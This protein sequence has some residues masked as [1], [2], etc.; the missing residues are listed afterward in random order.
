MEARKEVLMDPVHPCWVCGKNVTAWGQRW[1]MHHCEDAKCVNY[2][3]GFDRQFFWPSVQR[4]GFYRIF[5]EYVNHGNNGNHIVRGRSRRIR[6]K[7][8]Y[9]IAHLDRVPIEMLI[10]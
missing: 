9:T 6:T 10:H 4:Q 3:S 7:R 8:D 1:T 2:V 5:P